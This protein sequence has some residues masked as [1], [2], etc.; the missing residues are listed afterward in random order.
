MCN[1]DLKLSLS[2]LYVATPGDIA[3]VFTV[4][5]NAKEVI[6]IDPK[7]AEQEVPLSIRFTF[8]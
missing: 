6:M 8:N 1:P 7:I 4:D 3:R 2:K 5:N